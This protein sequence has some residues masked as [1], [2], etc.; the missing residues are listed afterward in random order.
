[1]CRSLG[2]GS[3]IDLEKIERQ[4]LTIHMNRRSPI[5]DPGGMTIDIETINSQQFT[6]HVNCQLPIIN[7]GGGAENYVA[8][9]IPAKHGV[10]TS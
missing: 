5:I 4:H 1:M 8:H 10:A 3:T 6:V 7:P 2:E 9:Y